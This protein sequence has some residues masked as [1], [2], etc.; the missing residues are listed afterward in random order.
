M[1]LRIPL[2]RHGITAPAGPAGYR[3]VLLDPA[4]RADATALR[5]LRRRS[6][7]AVVDNRVGLREELAAIGRRS[8]RA[9]YCEGHIGAGRPA[10]EE[11]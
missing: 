1:A 8:L 10:F 4:V 2:P 9:C 6:D 5:R 3:A 11:R 7:V